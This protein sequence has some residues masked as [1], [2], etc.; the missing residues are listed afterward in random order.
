M[1]TRSPRAALVRFLLALTVLLLL[2]GLACGINPIPTPGACSGDS[3]SGGAASDTSHG[4]ADTVFPPTDS[5]GAVDVAKGDAAAV[6]GAERPDVPDG[7]ADDGGSDP[8]ADAGGGADGGVCACHEDDDCA[9]LVPEGDVCRVARCIACQ[10]VARRAPIPC[11]THEECLSLQTRC[12]SAGCAG[13][14]CLTVDRPHCETA[15]A[16]DA[17]CADGDPCTED[18]CVPPAEPA[19]PGAAGECTHALVAAQPG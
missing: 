5:A 12:R 18:A 10:C 13:G 11:T 14:V 16:V 7:A 3:A 1:H 19:E 6:D 9:A 17:D 2:L 4:G 8:D 15:C